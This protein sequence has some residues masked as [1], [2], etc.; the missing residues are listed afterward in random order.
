MTSTPPV[1]QTMI[2]PRSRRLR[3]TGLVLL[4]AAVIVAL[5]GFFVLMPS[6]QR[7]M[8]AESREIQAIRAEQ[9][10]AT[11]NTSG[12]KALGNSQAVRIRRAHR[13]AAVKVLFAYGYW[14]VCG[15]LVV[16]MVFVAWL[17]LRE[18][19]RTYLSHRKAVWTETAS[20]LEAK[21]RMQNENSQ[22]EE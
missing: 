2:T 1:Y 9:A 6:L 16:A 11:P 13:V 18:V 7:A 4:V 3:T 21:K 14:S 12:T 8:V 15:L 5:Y 22:D 19:S 20:S 17:D 10:S